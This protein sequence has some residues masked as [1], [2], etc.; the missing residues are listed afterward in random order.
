MSID[1]HP[2]PI[3]AVA[4]DIVN[5]VAAVERI[6]KLFISD[7][8]LILSFVKV[9]GFLAPAGYATGSILETKRWRGA[10]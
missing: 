7:S 1:E 5:I 2:R 6:A 3:S 4:S 10:R 8:P 9:V